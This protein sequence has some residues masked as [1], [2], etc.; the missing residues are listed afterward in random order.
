[1]ET[2][3]KNPK[4]KAQ[5]GRNA[6][7]R[8]QHR[9]WHSPFGAI[10]PCFC[11][12]VNPNDYVELSVESQTICDKL[13]R[14]AFMRL[15]EHFNFYFVPDNML[16]MAFDNFITGQDNYFS[17]NIELTNQGNIPS[18]VPIFN[19]DFLANMF[20][21]LD[22]RKDIQGYGKLNQTARLLDLLG[23]GNYMPLINAVRNGQD[24][25]V[26]NGKAA[27]N[28]LEPMN[29][30]ALL[31]YQKV[32][33]DYFRNAK[34]EQNDTNAYNLD[35]VSGGTE[36][37]GTEQPLRYEPIFTMRYAWAKKDYFT[38]VQPSVLP[39]PSD[40]GYRGLSYGQPL[41]NVWSIFGVPGTNSEGASVAA[42]GSTANNF[43]GATD[44]YTQNKGQYVST[45]R[46]AARF[47]NVGGDT[48][49]TRDYVTATNVSALR[50]AFAYDKLMRR[51]REAGGTFDAQML[52]QF[53]IVP[54]DQRHGKCI[55]IGGQ[56]N[57]LNASDVVDV[58]NNLGFIG[59]NLNCY[60]P[61]RTTFKYHA[62]DHGIVIGVYN[63]S[64]DF[65]Y[66]SYAVERD[67]LAKQ[68]FDW[69][70][71]AFENLGLQPTFKLELLNIE[72]ELDPGDN[73][74]YWN[75]T[76]VEHTPENRDIL[77]Y[78]LRYQ[79]FKTSIDRVY[80]LYNFGSGDADRQAWVSQFLPLIQYQGSTVFPAKA[81]APF[82]MDSMTLSPLMFNQVLSVDYDGNW[83]TDPF[84]HN[85]Y[86]H[87]KCISNM[88][89]QGEVF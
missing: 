66:P 62:K 18:Q 14:P 77:G 74:Y 79:E 50:F 25:D 37:N 3:F 27:L 51:M 12:R 65:D 29:L 54:Y 56:T 67:N 78:S 7:D 10:L 80:G 9:V 53:G 43:P 81:V 87:F 1:M 48:T 2:I 26:T 49:S 82:A 13:V 36:L 17:T 21:Y 19:G 39:T 83:I 6:F 4:L 11:K 8:S 57:R 88:S 28:G 70:N 73:Q 64:L 69:F 68:R 20:G 24:F 63:T 38:D 58:A 32:Y 23:Y 47:Y 75:P 76:E 15:K 46:D 86:V 71:P 55:Y 61:A 45:A 85:T 60:S 31:A 22:H 52:A 44:A 40:I 34:Y 16:W 5:N 35:D 89:V 59:G 41:T 33:F 72:R 84:N 30:F 42:V